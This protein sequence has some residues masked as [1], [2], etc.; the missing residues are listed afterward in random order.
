[1]KRRTEEEDLE[2][3]GLRK[4]RGRRSRRRSGEGEGES[5]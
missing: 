1:M 2:G 5:I 3:G 4:M